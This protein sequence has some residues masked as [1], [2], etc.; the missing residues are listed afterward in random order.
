[1]K[2]GQISCYKTGKTAL[3]SSYA[4]KVTLYLEQTEDTRTG[5]SANTNILDKITEQINY[6]RHFA[7]FLHN[8]LCSLTNDT[9]CG[10]MK[11]RHVQD[12][13]PL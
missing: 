2:R 6:S 12:K 8:I 3:K 11:V 10:K 7:E 13:R 1:M 9:G 4:G 5:T